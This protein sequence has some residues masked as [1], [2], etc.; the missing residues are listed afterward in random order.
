MNRQRKIIFGANTSWYLWNFRAGLMRACKHAGDQVIAVAPHDQYS[1]NLAEEF[2]YLPIHGLERKG[3]NP[4]ADIRLFFEYLALYRKERP[5]LVFHFTIKPNIYGSLACRVL[6]IPCISNVTGLGFLFTQKNILAHVA[7]FLYRL[8]FTKNKKVVFQNI[9]D[10]NSFIGA[11]IISHRQAILVQG[12]GVDMNTFKKVFPV[13]P[14]QENGSRGLTFLL[15]ARMLKDKGVIEF[16]DAAKQVH[17]TFPEATFILAGGIDTGNPTA[18]TL[19]DVSFQE[20]WISYVGEI[21]NIANYLATSDVAVLPSYREGLPKGLLEAMA[22]ELPIITTDVPGCR[23]LI[24]DSKNG[25]LVP[26][27]NVSALADAMERM[28]LLSSD[29]RA[30][31]GKAGRA[32]VTE[33][34]DQ[35]IVIRKYLQMIEE[36]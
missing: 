19:E 21:S 7:K 12:S 2:S 11:G 24:E 16:I 32:M 31:M 18:L 22:M 3:K 27:R 33:K 13:N 8:A 30:E 26:V 17:A 23:D 35:E 34:F 36:I 25:F 15:A 4:F 14:S 6:G 29:A 20:S 9:D 10:M 1:K 28:I 5:D